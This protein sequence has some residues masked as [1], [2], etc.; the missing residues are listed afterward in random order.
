MPNPPKRLRLEALDDRCL[1]STYVVSTAG[2][3]ANPGTVDQP[4]ATIQTALR[5]ATHPGDVVQ[6]RAG[7]YRERVSFPAGGT[8]A[9]GYITLT[10]YP[11]EHPILDGTGLPGDLITIRNVNYVRVSGFQIANAAGAGVRVTGWGWND[12]LRDNI[13]HDV[14]GAAVSVTGTSDWPIAN[15]VVDRNEVYG[16]RGPAGISLNGNVPGLSVTGNWVHDVAG[17]GITLVGGDR[18]VNP[19]LLPA[20]NG[21]VRG[22]T[23]TLARAP[24]GA[25]TA[26]GIRVDGGQNLLLEGNVSYG[27]DVGLEVGASA[28]GIAATGV[29]VR[30]NL[31]Y[32][33][34]RA[35]L[36]IGGRS[37]TAGRAWYDTVVNNTVYQNDRLG[38]GAGQLWVG[39]GSWNVVASNVFWGPAGGVLVG[40]DARDMV[41]TL[42][43]NAYFADGADARFRWNGVTVTGLAAFQAATKSD[44]G[45]RV[46]APLLANPAGGDFHE[47][48]GSPTIDAGSTN[49]NRYAP[50]D[51]DGRRRPQGGAPDAGAFE[52]VDPN[53]PGG[54][55]LSADQKRR[56]E[57]L[58]SIF[59]NDT[60]ELQYAFVEALG[61]GR[62][63][64]AGRAG[65]TSATG[66]LLDVVERYSA[67]V[68]GNPLAGY[69]PRLRELAAYHSGSV[70]GLGGLPQAWQSAA[71]DPVFRAV[72]DQVVDETYY[73]PAL[74]RAAQQGLRT[75]LAIAAVYD[76][77]IQHGEGDDPDGL[78][79]LLTRTA[80]QAGGTPASGV[81]ERT[82]LD[83][84]LTVRRADLAYSY[85]PATRAGWAESVGRVD[86]FR[87]ILNAG[88]F[89]L[90]GPIRVASDVY[91]DFTIP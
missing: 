25:G 76:A 28:R 24:G 7:T 42:S 17:P 9:G 70:A 5:R 30:N 83:K 31:V 60:I 49:R 41:E 85:D 22:N 58:T 19:L 40:N 23:V 48:A 34:D 50:T 89:D 82:W 35:G 65:F 21:A 54:T 55:G 15:L 26:A 33:N 43:N 84:F 63:Y 10:N 46:A 79:A 62:G 86:V 59:E 32:Q 80:S 51:F 91:G 16:V 14:Q 29:T 53:P 4:F 77:I 90:A 57:Q 37:P 71:N 39:Y 69:L 20:R 38:T 44:A 3:D 11:G 78:P 72:Q 8:L 61:D 81:N 52:F 6:V 45:S 66:D 12:E 2:S 64:T 73:R 27:N 75:P 88:N 36:A 18:T 56:A 1:P 47:Q 67:R 74:A 68:P 87:Q 13:I